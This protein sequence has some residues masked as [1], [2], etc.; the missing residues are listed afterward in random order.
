MFLGLSN[1]EGRLFVLFCFVLFFVL[2]V[3][4]V[5]I[6]QTIVALVVVHMV[7]ESPQCL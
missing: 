5:E 7:L 6:S 2:F 1:K 4:H 3:C